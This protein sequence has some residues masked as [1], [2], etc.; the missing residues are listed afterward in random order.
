M[1]ATA[2]PSMQ[3]LMEGRKRARFVGRQ[4]E[5]TAFRANFDLPVEDDRHRFLFHVRGNAGVG[6]TTLLRELRDVAAGHGAV[7]AYADE[8]PSSVPEVLAVISACFAR[9]GHPLKALDRQLATYEQRRH[10]AEAAS[11][12]APAE[13]GPGTGPDG[14]P[15]AGSMALAQAGLVGAG[16]IPVVGALT[17]AVDPGSLAHGADRL[18][19]ILSA[20]FRNQEDVRLVLD[21]V[22]SL[23]PVL[24]AELDRVAAEAPWLTLFFDTYERTAPYLDTWLRDL[25]TTERYGALPATTV[26]VIAGRDRLDPASWPDSAFYARELAL[27]PFTEAE[28]RR[29][30]TGRGVVDEHVVQDVLRLSGGLPVLVSTLAENPGDAAVPSATAVDRFLRGEP[31]PDRHAAALACALPRRLDEDVFLAAVG[32]DADPGLLDWLRTLPFVSVHEGRLQYHDVVRGPMLYL[33]RTR[34]PR[35]WAEDHERLADAFAGRAGSA[36]EGVRDDERWEREEWRAARLEETYHR[37]CAR[38]EAALAEALRDGVDACDDGPATARRWV[39][40]LADA[41]EAAD[42]RVL[43]EWAGAAT[44]ALETGPEPVVAL[45]D[46]LL[47]RAAFGAAGQVA[48]LVARGKRRRLAEEYDAATADHER[49]LALDPACA[50]AHYELGMVSQRRGDLAAGLEHFDRADGLAPDTPWILAERGELHRRAGRYAQAVA[51]CDRALESGPEEAVVLATRGHA[52]FQLG[53]LRGALADLDRAVEKDVDYWWALL[54]RADV[55]FALGDEAGAMADLD[56]A[57]ER[58]P[59]LAWLPANRGYLHWRSGHHEQ[60][61]SDLDRALRLDPDYAWAL[62][63]KALVLADLGRLEEALSVLEAAVAARPDYGWALSQLAELQRRLGNPD[64]ESAVL[65]RAVASGD[66]VATALVDRAQA[67]QRAGRLEEALADLD[68]AIALKPDRAGALGV[69]CHVRRVQGWPEGAL[70]DLERLWALAPDGVGWALAALLLRE[71]RATPEGRAR[72]DALAEASPESVVDR[73]ARAAARTAAGRLAEALTDYDRALELSPDHRGARERRARVRCLLG[74]VPGG[75]ADMD[76]LVELKGTAALA[77]R[78]WLSQAVGRS[79]QALA[80]LERCPDRDSAWIT[81]RRAMAL[82]HL[83]R[84]REALQLLDALPPGDRG[85]RWELISWTLL[86][87][88]RP[89]EAREAAVRLR[90]T[91]PS[92]GL[93]LLARVE[94]RLSG[95]EAAA[96][97]WREYEEQHAF[98]V[99]DEPTVDELGTLAVTRAALG[100]WNGAGE[101]LERMLRLPHLWAGVVDVRDALDDLAASQ[102]AD[103]GR[104][105]GL[106][107]PLASRLAELTAAAED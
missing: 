27:R 41:G 34:S 54:R 30:L 68:R 17:G 69:R 33:Q 55:R 23:T 107:R 64:A 84:F 46:L 78:A 106:S 15:S 39:W 26:F 53:D 101:S 83:G 98:V 85:D 76:R 95:I 66:D 89:G 91:K 18:R 21:P 93:F 88:G 32:A 37:L 65:D 36:A 97:L 105:A 72:C 13:A 47:S 48:A 51:D 35:K 24:V 7:T 20:R 59:D 60:A 70:D 1:A 38:P 52:R 100:R 56:R 71:V 75:L 8:E 96:G 94:S 9:Q 40:T 86:R 50:R 10:E 29:L 80:D 11:A 49:A 31:D 25:V 14:P 81:G 22:R 79:R 67:H 43:R 99:A 103:T 77:E 57:E 42:A 2:R 44:N 74:D 19:G 82:F 63:S 12:S 28:S 58:R 4:E 5:I 62:G 3:A 102:G 6:K 92:E 87:L 104:F 45:L 90:E 61:L 16:M 73:L